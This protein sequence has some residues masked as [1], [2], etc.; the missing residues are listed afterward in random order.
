MVYKSALSL[1]DVSLALLVAQKSQMDPRE[2]LPFLQELQD[3]EPLRRKFLIDD[4][5]GNYEKALEHLSEIDKDGNVSEEVIDYVESHDLYKHGLALY[6]YDS[7]KQNVIYN[8]YA[9]HLSSNQMYTDAAV[10]YE[11]LGKLKEAMGAYQ[12]A[13]RW[14]EAMSIAVQKFPEE[15]E[16]VAEELISSLTFEHRY[17]DAADIQLEY[18]DNVKEAVALYCKAYR[19]DIASLVAIKAK[20]DEL[21]EE[22][23]DPGLGEGFGII[24]E[25]LADCKGQINSQLRRLRELRAKK[26]ENPYAFMARKLSKRM[27]FLLLLLRRQHKNHSSPDT[28]AKLGVLQRLVLP[29]VQLKTSVGKSVSVL[30]VRRELFMK[31]NIW[32]SQSED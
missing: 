18:L 21:L 29:D 10:A 20:K 24:A 32:F 8:I 11:M 19:Y 31:K 4:Y 9:K 28:Q 5:L 12:S 2:Y 17:V 7:E 13:K 22:V 6:R 3:N 27:T 15:V 26:E 14:R 16:S 23:V 1:Y 25:L 30:V